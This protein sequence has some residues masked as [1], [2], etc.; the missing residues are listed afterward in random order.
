[1]DVIQAGNKPTKAQRDRY[2]HVS[3][4]RA[5]RAETNKKCAYCESIY[6]HVSFG[7]IEHITPKSVKPENT[8]VWENL[9]LACEICNG[10]K[11]VTENVIDPYCHEP[12]DHLHFEGPVIIPW[13]GNDLGFNTVKELDLNRAK[14]LENRKRRRNDL[15]N[16]AEIMSMTNNPSKRATLR[17]LLEEVGTADSSQYAAMS[18]VLVKEYLNAVDRCSVSAVA[19]AKDSEW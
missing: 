3:I 13:P 2:R 15:Y 19:Q 12:S 17:K 6:S 18:R 14:L 4:K 7:D 11:S 16:I 1:M 10:N 5:L 9:T 8:Y